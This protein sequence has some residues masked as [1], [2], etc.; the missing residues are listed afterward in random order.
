VVV[1]EEARLVAADGVQAGI[2]ERVDVG[3]VEEGDLVGFGAAEAPEGGD[4]LFDVDLF[5]QVGGLVA[6]DMAVEQAEEEGRIL[7]GGYDGIQEQIPV[8]GGESRESRHILS[9]AHR[10]AHDFLIASRRIC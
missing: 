8:F 5:D 1:A 6:V 3:A 2:G 9:S 4:H 10:V 7:S